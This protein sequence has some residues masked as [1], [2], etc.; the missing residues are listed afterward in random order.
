V[1]Q[2]ISATQAVNF[3]LSNAGA[4]MLTGVFILQDLITRGEYISHL[5]W[6]AAKQ[7]RSVLSRQ[8]AS[9]T[10]RT[11]PSPSPSTARPQ[12]AEPAGGAR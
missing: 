12:P 3:D 5:S 11:S 6:N 7:I 9:L 10:L 8:L 2:A 4:D 1:K